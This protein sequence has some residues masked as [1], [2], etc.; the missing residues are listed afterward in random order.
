MGLDLLLTTK[1][2]DDEHKASIKSPRI[3]LGHN[4]LI[5]LKNLCSFVNF[6]WTAKNAEN[7]TTN[8]HVPILRIDRLAISSGSI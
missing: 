1:I 6:V 4:I 3:Q 5:P 2:H 8:T 7:S